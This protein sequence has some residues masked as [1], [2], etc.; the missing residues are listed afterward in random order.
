M[1]RA[2]TYGLP[3]RYV[4]LNPTKYW[5]PNIPLTLMPPSRGLPSNKFVFRVQPN[6]TKIELQNYVSQLY[7]VK[8]TKVNT[9]NYEG[10]VKRGLRAGKFFRT[11]RYK[12]AILTTDD[13]LRAADFG[14]SGRHRGSII[15]GEVVEKQTS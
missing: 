14:D 5:L 15:E 11:R 12:K 8:V 9:M 13:T 6:I 3:P 10:K 2:S 4:G 1:R 7:G